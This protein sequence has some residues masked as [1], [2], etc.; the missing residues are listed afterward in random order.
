MALPLIFFVI[1]IGVDQRCS[2]AILVLLFLTYFVLFISRKLALVNLKML[3]YSSLIWVSFFLL[4]RACMLVYGDAFEM[5]E[6]KPVYLA[7]VEVVCTDVPRFTSR[8]AWLTAP[9]TIGDTTFDL[10]LSMD[11]LQAARLEKGDTLYL[12]GAAI[13]PL[14]LK[15]KEVSAWEKYLLRQG[16]NYKSALQKSRSWTLRKNKSWYYGAYNFAHQKIV[17]SALSSKS[18]ALLLSLLIGDRGYIDKKTKEDYAV[19]G[20]SHILSVSGL[21]VGI[22]YFV[23]AWLLSL[24]FY[25]RSSIAV[26]LVLLVIWFYCW[27]VG[28]SPPVL[29]SALMFSLFVLASVVGRGASLWHSTCWSAFV[30]LLLQP[31]CL[32]DIGFQLSYGAML[33]IVF[34][35]PVFSSWV[36]VKGLLW[37]SIVDL[38]LLSVAV[39][40]TLLPFLVY[41]FEYVSLYF[42]LANIVIVPAVALLMYLGIVFLLASGRALQFL[43]FL[44]DQL[45]CFMDWVCGL[46]RDAP[47][48]VIS[49]VLPD[50]IFWICYTLVLIFVI[51]FKYS[52]LNWFLYLALFFFVFAILSI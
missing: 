15:G 28:F 41:Y 24:L 26:F 1:G 43:I 4:G 6:L 39:Q 20:V 7:K 17:R 8:G 31:Q 11:S 30:I 29:R 38:L 47:Y 3:C 33:G 35:M 12:R 37:K 14:L 2:V 13:W 5:G 9:A 10:L 27:M 21:H 18:K 50:L 32:Y 45:V 19:L 36:K 48:T 22:V 16:V 40:L 52:R 46:L 42:L 23:V 44:L 51:Y 49:L 25:K 34:V